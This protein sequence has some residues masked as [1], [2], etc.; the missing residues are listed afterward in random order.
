MKLATVKVNSM[1]QAA[2]VYNEGVI[3]IRDINRIEEAQWETDVFDLLQK[4]QLE[5]LNRWYQQEGID[6]L[7]VE[8]SIQMKYRGS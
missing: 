2:I 6:K 8:R 7:M 3:L 4:N 1:E 5:Q